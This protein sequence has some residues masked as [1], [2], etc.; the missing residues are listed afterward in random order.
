MSAR[1]SLG[2][3]TRVKSL[4]KSYSG[5]LARGHEVIPVIVHGAVSPKRG[6]MQ[7]SK[8]KRKDASV[9]TKEERC[10]CQHERGRMQ[11]SAREE[12]DASV[13]TREEGCTCHHRGKASEKLS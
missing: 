12:K 2:I 1:K 9:S 10:K 3:Q 13:S 8:R 4:H 6:R 11:V 5:H 7:V